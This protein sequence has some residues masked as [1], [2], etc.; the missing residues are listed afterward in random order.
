MKNKFKS[1]LRKFKR[2]LRKYLPKTN[3]PF[4]ILSGPN[5][6]KKIFTNLH[7]YP[8]G[9]LG[10]TEHELLIWFSQNIN[11]GENWLDVGANFGYTVIGINYFLGDKGTIYAFEP[12]KGTFNA[13]NKT[14]KINSM[15]NVETY[16]LA[17]SNNKELT[18]KNFNQVRGMLTDEDNS[19]DLEVTLISFDSF[20]S[21]KDIKKIDGIKIDVD[22]PELEVL[23]GLENVI[24]KDKPKIVIEV[25][26]Q[27][28]N[29]VKSLLSKYGYN[30]YKVIYKPFYAINE[31]VENA[32]LV[33]YYG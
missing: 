5:K 30:K 6:G 23:L 9:I 1:I 28:F 13:L 32:N 12:V 3:Y 16:C 22:G 31:S 8:S 27:S 17:L 11:E 33:F 15:Q 24:S 26:D 20:F 21:D 14:I 4:K 29:K 19:S 25:H 10:T 7:D 2:S 18:K